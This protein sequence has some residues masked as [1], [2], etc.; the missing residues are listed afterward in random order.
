MQRSDSGAYAVVV[1]NAAGSATSLDAV[2]SL[3]AD[4]DSGEVVFNNR[5]PGLVDVRVILPDGTPAGAGWLAQLYGGP[6]GGTLAPLFPFTGFRTTSDEARGYVNPV[7]VSVTGVKSGARATLVVRVYNG[8][9]FEASTTALESN[10]FTL[11]AGGGTLPPPNL[12]GLKSFSIVKSEFAK[13]FV[14]RQLPSAYSPGT[15]FTVTSE[16]PAKQHQRLCG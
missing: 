16:L 13:P 10:P 4:P 2:V 15:K 5:V 12:E 3:P 8:P 11:V 9:S 6:E 7:G 14:E 1:S